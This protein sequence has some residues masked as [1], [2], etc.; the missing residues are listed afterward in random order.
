MNHLIWIQKAVE[1]IV[2]Q[3]NSLRIRFIDIMISALQEDVFKDQNPKDE[4]LCVFQDIAGDIVE[5]LESLFRG[6]MIHYQWGARLD[7]L[8]EKELILLIQISKSTFCQPVIFN[9]RISLIRSIY[10]MLDFCQ[11]DFEQFKEE[12]ISFVNELFYIIDADSCKE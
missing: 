8:I 4:V 2:E 9:F 1:I 10:K 11:R 5:G 7:E 3:L 12:P 6:K